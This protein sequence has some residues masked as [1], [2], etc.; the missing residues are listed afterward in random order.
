MIINYFLLDNIVLLDNKLFSLY[1]A[2]FIGLI[3]RT[4]LYGLAKKIMLK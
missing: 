4:G 3:D 1:K 2:I